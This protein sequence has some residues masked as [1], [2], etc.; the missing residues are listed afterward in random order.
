MIDWYGVLVN[1]LWIGGIAMVWAVFSWGAYARHERVWGWR[2]VL[3]DPALQK[4]L[5]AGL[6]LIALGLS[7][8]PRMPLVG[9]AIGGILALGLTWI[10]WQAHRQQRGMAVSW[11]H[12]IRTL[13]QGTRGHALILIL[14]GVLL[15][16]MYAWV[17]RP[18]MQPDEPRH[19]EVAMHDARLKRPGATS[20][21]LVPA[22]EQELI[23]DMEAQSFWWYGYSVIGWDPNHLPQAFTEI[24][25]PRYSRAFFQLP[26]YYD[27]AGLW[28]YAWGDEMSLSQS[29]ILLRFFGIFWLAWSLA[30]IY[31]MGR[32]L[33]PHR[34]HIALGALAF[35]ALW[36]SH[37]AA[38]AAVNNDP[39][40]E[41]LVI[42]TGVFAI[43]L[44]RRGPDFR[45]LSL[46][47]LCAILAIYTKRT[48]FSVLI[49]LGALPLWGLLQGFRRRATRRGRMIG[50]AVLLIGIVLLPALFLLI[51]ATGRY[52]IPASLLESVQTGRLWQAFL[53]AP[54]D[55]FLLTLY[56][57]FWGWFGWLR[58]GLPE[59]LYAV[60]AFLTLLLVGWMVLGY[61]HIFSRKL[62]DWQRAGLFLLFLALLLQMVLV[63]G[64]D[65][66]YGDW[67]GGSVPQIRY[68]YPVLPALVLPLFLGM[69]RTLP[70]AW[71][72]WVI[73][74][75]VLLFTLF[76]FYILG[77]ILYPF[78]WL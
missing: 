15:A 12:W 40:A 14:M 32:T 33:F 57:T 68:L 31:M 11:H 44:L 50:W 4:P 74:G 71:H 63:L 18:W 49:F 5:A 25:E 1:G 48:A 75:A 54:I 24:W 76:N 28:L 70:W 21:D 23:R 38:N 43:R 3:S 45:T 6:A 30:G 73:P 72:R 8:H 66:I 56:R 13:F 16:S 60:A 29:V 53:R 37:L 42:W 20:Q 7:L 59:P 52:W 10:A 62:A 27:L 78:F 22:W 26:L 9:S 58:V 47:F 61:L 55:R 65:V 17:I 39:M 69:Y 41:A 34:P 19:Y 77:M 36:P 64:K 35:A 46:F 51:Q 2:A 67:Q